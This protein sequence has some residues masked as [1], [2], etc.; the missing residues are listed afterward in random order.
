MNVLCI[1]LRSNSELHF[2]QELQD[3]QS[4]EVRGQ[5]TVTRVG[6]A[7]EAEMI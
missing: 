3:S 1:G 5:L 2:L 4:A 7:E 6:G